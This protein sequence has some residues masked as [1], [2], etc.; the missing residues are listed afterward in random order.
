MFCNSKVYNDSFLLVYS[1]LELIFCSIRI[2]LSV[3]VSNRIGQQLRVEFSCCR[4]MSCSAIKISNWKI[5][6]HCLFV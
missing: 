3:C 1:L 5:V 4:C 2:I 6:K